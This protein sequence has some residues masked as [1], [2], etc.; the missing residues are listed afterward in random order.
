MR[1]KDVA[2]KSQEDCFLLFSIRAASFEAEV[3]AWRE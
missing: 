1:F 2:W 3:D